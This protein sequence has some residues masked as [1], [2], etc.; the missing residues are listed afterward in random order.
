LEKERDKSSQ[1]NTI[2]LN[3]KEQAKNKFNAINVKEKA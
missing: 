3:V 1:K 2:V